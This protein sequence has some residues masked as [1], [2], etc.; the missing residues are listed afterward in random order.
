MTETLLKEMKQAV[1]ENTFFDF[2][3][4]NYHRMEREDL[5]QIIMELDWFI[6]QQNETSQREAEKYV[7]NVLSEE[8]E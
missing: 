2:I 4:N 7:Y 5:K 8:E 1:E 6:Y 3:S